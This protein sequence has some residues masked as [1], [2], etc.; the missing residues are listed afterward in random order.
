MPIDGEFVA[1]EFIQSV[2]GAEPQEAP[3]ILHDASD[4][5]LREPE[6]VRDALEV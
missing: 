1:V 5:I 6:V 2:L 3:A 4:Q